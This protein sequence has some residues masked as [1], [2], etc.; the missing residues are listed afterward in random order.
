MEKK[1]QRKVADLSRKAKTGEEAFFA[2]KKGGAERGRYGEPENRKGSRTAK[3]APRLIRWKEGA[4]R[5]GDRACCK[6]HL[7]RGTPETGRG[8][9][10]NEEKVNR[11]DSFRE[12]K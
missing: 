8:L 11:S 7:F 12:K 2:G 3:S 5:V 10:T 4:I 9:R 6:H 1:R